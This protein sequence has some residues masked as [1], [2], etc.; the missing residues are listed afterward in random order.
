MRSTSPTPRTR[1][2]PSCW[3][4][5]LLEAGERE[6]AAEAELSLS[7][8]WWHRGQK[9]KA[10]AHEARA[11]ELVGGASSATACRVLAYIARTRTIAGEASAGLRL[12]TQALAMADALQIEELRA[13]A[14]ATVGLAKGYL[15]EP[16][17]A[18]D[19]IQALEIAMA[20]NS[21]FAGSIANNVAVHAIFAFDLQRAAALFDEGLQIAER[22][23]DAPG[24]RWLRG[25]Q[26]GFGV[27]FERWDDVSRLMDEFIAEC[28]AGSPHYTEATVRRERARI[29]EARGDRAGALADFERA[30]S[31][32][33][34]TE[35]PQELLRSWEPWRWPTRSTDSSIAFAPSPGSSS[36]SPA[37]IQDAIWAVSL[38][39][40]ARVALEHERAS[41]DPRNAPFPKWKELVRLPRSRLRPR[42]RGLG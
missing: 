21:P 4:D 30:V 15:G 13:H 27:F 36:T 32:A 3:R 22:Y 37:C 14:L 24:A 34:H 19:E 28:E 6:I 18:D 26:A 12:A 20:A 25:Q 31:L 9:D 38:D 8:I 29:R 23:G 11:E 40:L 16:S 39:F 41:C 5:A 7:R 2:L 10:S 33:R 35:D 17:G 42:C 1:R